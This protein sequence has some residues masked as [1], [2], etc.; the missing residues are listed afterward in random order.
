[1]ILLIAGLEPKFLFSSI[2]LKFSGNIL[3][4]WMVNLFTGVV[5]GILHNLILAIASAVVSNNLEE[6]IEQ[7]NDVINGGGFA[8]N[9]LP[10]N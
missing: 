1:M 8:S 4:D 3:T 10:Y 6:V 5:T 7:I 2:S 9:A